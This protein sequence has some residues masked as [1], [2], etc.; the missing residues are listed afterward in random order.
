MNENT[1]TIS[2]RPSKNVTVSIRTFSA[3]RR[4]SVKC[5]KSPATLVIS[6]KRVTL[7][8]PSTRAAKRIRSTVRC[9]WRNVSPA[10]MVRRR[11]STFLLLLRRRQ[12]LTS[13]MRSQTMSRRRRPAYRAQKPSP[14]RSQRATTTPSPTTTTP[15]I[16][17]RSAH[18]SQIQRRTRQRAQCRLRPQRQQ[19]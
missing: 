4:V 12:T 5:C 2:T 18:R 7:R 11:R 13:M 3:V 1:T 16:T 10:I 8:Q 14:R 19:Q 9:P 6:H 15:S 17:I